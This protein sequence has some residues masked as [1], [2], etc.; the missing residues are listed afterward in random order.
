MVG[1]FTHPSKTNS[2]QVKTEKGNIY[3]IY[4]LVG[5]TGG[6]GYHFE[7]IK[8]KHIKIIKFIWTKII[9]LDV[10]FGFMTDA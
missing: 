4:F 1:Q 8:Q 6:K 9:D 5:K 10:S 2:C 7:K 3:C